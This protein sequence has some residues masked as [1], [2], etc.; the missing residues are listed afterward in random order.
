MQGETVT[1]GV[2]QRLAKALSHP[3]RVRVLTLLN[4]R[5]ASPSEL[6]EELGAPLGNVAY[7]VRILLD[8]DLLELVSTT[9]RR[10][11]VEHHYRAI[12]R[13]WLTPMVLDEQGLDEVA[14]VLD[15]ALE[16][17]ASIQGDAERR[18]SANGNE[19]DRIEA[20][21]VLMHHE[22]GSN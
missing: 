7:H 12:E 3:L 4:Q 15:D 22:A 13:P 16:R 10:G 9:P 14:G 19:A 2:E 21:V 17:L 11:A 20:R 1:A 8:L 18:L 6:A 5:V